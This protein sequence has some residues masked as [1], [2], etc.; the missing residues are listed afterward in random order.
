M[1]PDWFSRFEDR[2]NWTEFNYNLQIDL[3]RRYV[4]FEVP[5]VA[6]ST[7]K[8]R[9]QKIVVGDLAV[10]DDPHPN[11][12]SSPF[13]KPYQ[14]TDETMEDVLAGRG[15]TRFTFVREPVERM[16][17]AYLDKIVQ[18]TTHKRRFYA[19]HLPHADPSEVIS[20]DH[21]VDLVVATEMAKEIDK[22]WRPQAEI[23]F[24][25]D[26]KLDFVGRFDRF[27]TDWD[28]LV[29]RI[30]LPVVEDRQ[31]V[32]FHATAATTR[33]NEIASA[34]ARRKIEGFC[35]ADFELFE[36]AA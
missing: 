2:C 30:D 14:L 13:V 11:V 35:A 28:R 27:E 7:I 15:F 22:H 17:S 9:L 5:K 19:T 12:Y 21:F 3:R 34:D 16:V 29:R 24:Q 6:C 4:Y 33:V 31:S 32:R 8:A 10:P 18:D 26:Q 1:K 36:R 20:F 25:P 23:L